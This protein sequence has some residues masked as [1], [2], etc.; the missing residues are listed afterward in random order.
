MQV[1]TAILLQYANGLPA[2]FSADCTKDAPF[3]SIV[4][5]ERRLSHRVT[6]AEEYE[7]GVRIATA[8]K[9][10]GVPVFL[11]AGMPN[12][13]KVSQGKTVSCNSLLYD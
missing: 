4:G 10:A 2:G 7:Q 5:L 8:A 3:K 6:A 12:V 9:D 1:G 13:E 11:W